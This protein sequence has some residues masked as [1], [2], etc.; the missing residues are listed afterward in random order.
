VAVRAA[1]VKARARELGFDLCGISPVDD[2]P[3]LDTL[4]EWLD[5]G[6]AGEMAWMTRTADRR[7]DV[8][9]VMPQAQSVIVTG[10]LYNTE[11]PYSAD[12]PPDAAR[13][14]RYAWGDDYHVIV[15]QRLD[16]LVEW[17]RAA[18]P[19]PFDARIYVDTGPIQERVYGQYAGLGWIGKNTCLIDPELGSWI[20]LGCLICSLPL[21]AD[22]SGLD[23]CGDCAACLSACP[24]GALVAPRELDAT[25]CIS[26]LTIEQK[27]AIPEALRASLGS[28]VYGCDICQDVC[29]WNRHAAVSEAPEW[30]PRA[31]LDRA[32]A[33]SL[34]RMSDADLSA[35]MANTP[36]ERAGVVKFRRN[37]AVALANAHDVRASD[38]DG[39]DDPA[40]P[41][42]A[43][44]VV[45]EHVR[46]ARERLG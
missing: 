15:R 17:M 25:K 38:V 6:Y 14:S 7:R 45:A 3:E 10:T 9:G 16:A 35:L 32:D 40:R 37:L 28:L 34:W 5:R 42:I 41:S 43:N 24:T 23:Q 39:D 26:Y 1:D 21:E 12:L 33:L 19:E 44:P 31:P 13:I 27:S 29:P 20:F 8:R 11:R 2:F 36:M 30:L 46:W 18:H 4:R 22:A